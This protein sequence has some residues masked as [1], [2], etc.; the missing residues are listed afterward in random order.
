MKNGKWKIENVSF[1]CA[2]DDILYSDDIFD[3]NSE[4]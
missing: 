1:Y 3:L 2:Q 4:F